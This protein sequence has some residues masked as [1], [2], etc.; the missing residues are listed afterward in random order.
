MTSFPRASKPL[1]GDHGSVPARRIAVHVEAASELELHPAQAQ[2]LAIGSRL[3]YGSVGLN[4]VDRAHSSSQIQ[5]AQLPTILLPVM[6]H[7]ASARALPVPAPWI[8][9]ALDDL[10]AAHA[11]DPHGLL[12]VGYL[13]SVDQAEVIARWQSERRMPR[14]VLDP[15]LGDVELGFYTDPALADAIRRLLLPLADGVT[16]NLFELAHLSGRALDKL[17]SVAAIESAARAIMSE[18][19]EWVIV[20]GASAPAKAEDGNPRIGELIVTRTG[21]SFHDHPYLH[22]PAKG[23]GDAF[24]ATLNIA[25]LQGHDLDPAVD[26]AARAVSHHI[27]ARTSESA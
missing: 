14:F 26:I 2:I 11:L 23:L 24:A 20:T 6:P 21:S 13:A 1:R 9:D 12:T 8:A 17:C 19:T 4:A 18:K 10:T 22:T 25:L 15:T 16:P 7:Y 27:L 3:V 5:T